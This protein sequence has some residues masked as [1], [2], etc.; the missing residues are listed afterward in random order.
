MTIPHAAEPSASST[1][2]PTI[3][4]P[5]VSITKLAHYLAAQPEH[6]QTVAGQ[7]PYSQTGNCRTWYQRGL[8]LL[9]AKHYDKAL[10]CFS[11]AIALDS[12]QPDSWHMRGE[13]LANLGMHQDALA[14]F[15]QA[16]ELKADSCKAWVFR[17]V[18]L[19]HLQQFQ[20]A[21]ESCDRALAMQPNDPEAWMF[22]GSAL[23]RLGRY[24][25]AYA[26]FD[27]STGI[28]RQSLWQ[29]LVGLVASISKE[30]RKAWV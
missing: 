7:E 4:S 25:E 23:Q 10:E 24:K 30:S 1:N 18:V 28:Q 14:C 26:S 15:D 17:A 13:V 6:S 20:N 3:Q 5:S 11:Q 8:F 22:R 12:T 2:D 21:I 9:A 27:K 29:W 16:L 19:I